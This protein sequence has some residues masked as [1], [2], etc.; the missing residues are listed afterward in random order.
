MSQSAEFIRNHWTNYWNQI[1]K[2]CHV[3][4]YRGW[5][6]IQR[7]FNNSSAYI[8]DFLFYFFYFVL[9][10]DLTHFILVQSGIDLTSNVFHCL[11]FKCK[12]C[13]ERER[14]MMWPCNMRRACSVEC[15]W[16]SM[17]GWCWVLIW[18]LQLFSFCEE[19]IR[20]WETR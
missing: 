2:F 14:E 6:K 12:K 15:W 20:Q 19:F 4:F 7:Q 16:L 13:I 8:K 17:F 3:S 18:E 1:L 11:H 9:I 10:L 5:M